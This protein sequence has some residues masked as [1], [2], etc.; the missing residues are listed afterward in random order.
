MDLVRLHLPGRLDGPPAAVA[1][2]NFDGVHRGHQALVTEVVRHARATAACALVL[3]FD[4]HP[5]QVVGGGRTPAT[6]MTLEQKAEA[7]AG[8]GVDRMVVLPFTPALAMQPPRRF[9]EV[10][11]RDAVRAARVVVG[12]NFRFGHR[13][14]GDVEALRGLGAELGFAVDA[15]PPVVEGGRPIS[16]SRIREALGAGDVLGAAGLL[17]RPYAVDGTVVKG[18]GRGRTIGIPTANL[19][20]VNEITPAEGVYAC[21]FR[22][23]GAAGAARPAVVNIGRRPTF[24]EGHPT[25]EAHVL[26]FDGDLYGAPVRLELI[27]RIRGERRFPGPEALVARIREDIAHARVLLGPSGPADPGRR[28]GI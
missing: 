9:A 5:S 16:S 11:L 26:D 15:M 18:A 3:S 17:G 4:P 8:L 12:T 22:G 21:W 14:A 28:D 7:L 10:V 27:A 23:G 24:G 19:Q 20:L 13:R 6:L 25:I 2:G 1:V